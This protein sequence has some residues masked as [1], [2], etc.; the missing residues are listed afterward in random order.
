MRFQKKK[1]HYIMIIIHWV[2]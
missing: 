1:Q 2:L